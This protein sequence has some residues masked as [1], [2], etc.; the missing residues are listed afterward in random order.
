MN[1]FVETLLDLPWQSETEPNPTYDVVIIGGG[2]HGLATAYYLATRH[3]ITNVCVLD[4]SYIGSGNSGRN[5]TII[6][7]NYGIPESVAFYQE[8]LSMYE[9]LEEETGCWIMHKTKGQLWMAHSTGTARTEQTRVLMN[10]ACG[11]PSEYLSPA[12]IKE[13]VPQIDLTGG[14]RYPV[15]GS[16]YLHGGATARH[17]RVV[18]AY[19]QGALRAGAHIFQNTAVTGLVKDGARVTGVT[20]SKGTISAGVV[21]SA[22][23]GHVSTVSK[24]ADVR[25]PIRTHTLQAFVTNAYAQEFAPIVSSNDLVFYISQTARG[26]M[27]M[28]AEY[29]RQASYQRGTNFTYLQSVSAKAV[30]LFPFMAKLRILRTWA[31]ICDVSTDFSPI[32]GYTNTSGFLLS[33]GWGTWGFKAIP[34]AGSQLAKLIADDKT[35]ELIAP[36]A[37]SRFEREVAMADPSSAGTK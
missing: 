1:E 29:D 14:G 27:L 12:Q 31:G 10:N 18:W 20:T 36:F 8:S 30:T 7:S 28:G 24:W 16:S 22:V 23:G 5:T 9:S 32:M 35:P 26:Q 25:L 4:A 33:T 21:L 34:A 3:G 19:A 11:A 13:I 2:G 6:R 37:L 17:D 15:Q